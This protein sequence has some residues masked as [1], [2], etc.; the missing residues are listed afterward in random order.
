MSAVW[1]NCDIKDSMAQMSH[2]VAIIGLQLPQHDHSFLA[3]WIQIAKRVESQRA[4]GVGMPEQS[5]L[6]TDFDF[7]W[8]RLFQAGYVYFAKGVSVG[9]LLLEMGYFRDHS[10]LDFERE[11]HRARLFRNKVESLKYRKK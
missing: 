2:E 4:N 5:L 11:L 9:N 1:A 8:F 10:E 3:S 6:A 7:P